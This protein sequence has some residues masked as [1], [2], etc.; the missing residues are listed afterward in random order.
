MVDL[1]TYLNENHIT[2]KERAEAEE[3][4]K[5]LRN[6]DKWSLSTSKVIEDSL[7]AFGKSHIADYPSQSLIFN[8]DNSASYIENNVLTLEE[9]QEIEAFKLHEYDEFRD[10]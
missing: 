8:A 4:F 1:R 3:G 9:I 7:Y 5:T 2:V 10:I 6:D